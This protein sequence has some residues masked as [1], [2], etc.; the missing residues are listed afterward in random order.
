MQ[1]TSL[2]LNVN[3]PPQR[4]QWNLA[5]SCQQTKNILGL[6]K[7]VKLRKK[8]PTWIFYNFFKEKNSSWK[9]KT[10]VYVRVTESKQSFLEGENEGEKWSLLAMYVLQSC[11]VKHACRW[12]R[13]V[14]DLMMFFNLLSRV[15]GEASS[16]DWLRDSSHPDAELPL[17]HDPPA[18]LAGRLLGGCVDTP[19]WTYGGGFGPH[20]VFT[21]PF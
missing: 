2:N 10:G 12:E 15:Q 11:Q 14:L 3:K 17:D 1:L 4:L 8:F 13:H 16:R 18:A 20:H 5:L 19:I 6:P 9:G 21:R 7:F